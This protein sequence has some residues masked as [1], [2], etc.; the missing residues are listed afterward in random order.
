MSIHHLGQPCSVHTGNT[1]ER[2]KQA[3]QICQQAGA[4]FT[5]LREAVYRLILAADRPL[6]AYD[7]LSQL[8]AKKHASGDTGNIA[9]PTVYRSLEFLLGFNLIHQLSSLSAYVPCCHPRDEHTA[10]FLI[11]AACQRVQEL[12]DP[13]I[14]QLVSHSGT[15]CQFMVKKTMI[16]LLGLCRACQP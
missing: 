9:P 7:V 2:I 11:C 16:E 12:S 3:K 1:T 14:D 10:S 8:Q 6:G 15:Q 13:P 4:R 5:P